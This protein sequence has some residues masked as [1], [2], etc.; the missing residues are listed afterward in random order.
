MGP[1]DNR[2][3]ILPEDWAVNKLLPMMSDKVFKEL[4]TRY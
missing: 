2:P 4:R 1:R 3:F